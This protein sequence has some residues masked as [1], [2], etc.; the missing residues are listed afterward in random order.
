[1]VSNLTEER[2]QRL[3]D[4][5]H[6]ARELGGASRAEF[7]ARETGSDPELRIELEEM[8]A[9]ADGASDRIA[10]AI[11]LIAV[12]ASTGSGWLGR[13]V[14]S[15][16][17]VREI[18]RGGMGIVFEAHSDDDEYRKTV[19]IKLATSW[20]ASGVPA[21]FRNE[22]QILAGLEHPN[23]ERLLDGGS[24]DRVPYFAMEHVEGTPIT[25]YARALALRQRIQ[26]FQQVC[27]AVHYAHQSLI[28][29]RDLKPGNILV[30][31]EGVP[32]L[33]DFGIAKLLSPIEDSPSTTATGVA[34]CTPDYASP[35]QILGQ[36]VTTRTDV[37]SLGLILFELLTEERAQKADTSS[38]LA[39]HRSVCETSLPLAS[40]KAPATVARQLTGDL[41]TIIAKATQK[42][43]HRRYASVAEF[44][45][46]LDRYMEGR[47]VRAR[48][49]TVAYRASKF[50]RRNW[51][52][53]AAATIAIAALAAG[54]AGFAWQARIARRSLVLAEHERD[55]ATREHTIA[56]QQRDE[57][58][59]QEARA[60]DLAREA[61]AQRNRAQQRTTEL[62]GLADHAVLELYAQIANLSGSLEARRAMLGTTV[63]YLE[64]L[65]A[66]AGGDPEFL[67]LLGDSYQELGD[68]QGGSERPSLGDFA[69]AVDYY[70]KALGILV[71]LTARYPSDVR[72]RIGLVGSYD[73]MGSALRNTGKPAEAEA[74]FL[75]GLQT[76]RAAAALAPDDVKALLQVGFVSRDLGRL[77]MPNEPHRAEPY[78][79]ESLDIF[80]RLT[81]KNSG[82]LISLDNLASGYNLLASL[83]TRDHDMAS[84]LTYVRKA[85]DV[86]EKLMAA[87]PANVDFERN[88]LV[89]YGRLGDIYGAAFDNLGEPMEAA[90]WFRKSIDLANRMLAKDPKSSTARRDLAI[91][92]A[93]AGQV[94]EDPDHRGESIELLQS[95]RVNFETLMESSPAD[96]NVRLF[97]GNA[98]TYLAVRYRSA[99]ENA[100]AL[101]AA[102]LAVEWLTGRPTRDPNVQ[103]Q[104]AGARQLLALLMGENGD[105][106]RA[107][108]ESAKAAEAA[109]LSAGTAAAN[110]SGRMTVYLSRLGDT[111]RAL[112]GRDS[113]TDQKLADWQAAR[114]AYQHSAKE[115]QS[116][117]V[118][119]SKTEVPRLQ[120]LIAECDTA[121]ASLA[122]R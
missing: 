25:E 11:S 84:S 69:G 99:G 6:A 52:P 68:L 56:G 36:P 112:A 24:E 29:H 10:G 51:L 119:K 33:L 28:V 67:L 88:L 9:N 30:T 71:P 15:Y 55:T 113:A 83:A 7:I 18:G 93:R 49:D 53:V 89:S 107:R 73:R 64:K 100:N 40:A 57:A 77:L 104:I 60:Q 42:D 72:Y 1:M 65:R 32:K 90:A 78:V 5:F 58:L 111:H 44:S 26:I 118:P 39:F 102:R 81:A 115:W 121:I 48:K 92:Q 74:A 12:E 62:V 34:R 75:K 108:E 96:M 122:P 31:T 27:S 50:I 35:E 120:G 23:I 79:R 86:R 13:R 54:A 106:D 59:R 114:E 16:R 61:T 3:Q 95:A 109:R 14:G 2:W 8:L 80:T 76:A 103:N 41:D 82:D 101:E 98:L 22:R 38:P 70:N 46:D 117:G 63:A 47:P 85:V 91:S 43:P 17:L 21:D 66:E 4:L 87:D 110:F 94:L 19:A 20:R 116:A 37:Y 97:G 45:E 105:P